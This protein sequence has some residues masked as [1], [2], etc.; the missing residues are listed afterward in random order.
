VRRLQ[1]KRQAR[2]DHNA[3]NRQFRELQRLGRRLLVRLERLGQP[4]QPGLVPTVVKAALGHALGRLIA[5]GLAVGLTF[6]AAAWYTD[7][8]IGDIV[9]EV[10]SRLSVESF[11][12]PKSRAPTVKP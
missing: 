9:D 3:A 12:G 6:V 10:R 2:T 8:G 7:K 5:T 1:R 11:L 4:K